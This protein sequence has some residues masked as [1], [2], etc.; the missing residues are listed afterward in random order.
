MPVMITPSLVPLTDYWATIL[1]VL[2]FSFVFLSYLAAHLLLTLT[3]IHIT[4]I[5]LSIFVHTRQMN[6]GAGL[7]RSAAANEVASSVL[8]E[9]LNLKRG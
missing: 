9:H 7:K 5:P 4:K 2:M 1:P 8:F 6:Y 3:I